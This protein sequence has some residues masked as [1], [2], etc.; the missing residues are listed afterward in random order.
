MDRINYGTFEVFEFHL[1][2]NSVHNVLGG[3]FFCICPPRKGRIL[4]F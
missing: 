2:L 1:V 4:F 3:N